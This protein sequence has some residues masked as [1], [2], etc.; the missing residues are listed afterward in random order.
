MRIALVAG[1]TSGDALG[2]ELIES[3]RALSPNSEFFGIGGPGMAA[4]GCKSWFQSEELSVM[5]L[6]EVLRHLPRLFKVRSDLIRKLL[7]AKPD[8]FVGIDS[9]DFNLPVED[10]LREKGIPTVQYVSPQVWA[11]RR[12]RVARIRKATDLVLCVLPFEVDFYKQHDVKAVFV[13]HPLADQIPLTVSQKDARSGLGFLGTAPL[14]AVLPGSRRSEVSRL[15]RPFFETLGWLTEHR[16]G[17]VFAVAFSSQTMRDL[18]MERTAGIDV[19]PEPKFFVGK[20][21]EVIAAS[22]VVL[23]A[24]GTASLEATLLKRP[25]V[26]AYR[27]SPLTHWMLNSMGVRRL[28]NF[29]LPNLLAAKSLMP[30]YLQ[31][32]VRAQIL[33]P[34]LLNFL[35]DSRLNPYW[36]DAF[37]AIHD[38][39]RCGASEQ[40]A[41]AVISLFERRRH[42]LRGQFIGSKGK[43][44]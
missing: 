12:S 41:Q 29:S 31:A 34:A 11:W 19:N 15:S 16:S 32:Q 40:A 42:D 36:Y 10:V 3:I 25:M 43:S 28:Q 9:P 14:V 35:D 18:F 24:S 30:E 39:L 22:D 33:G 5:G 21:R 4:V 37:A 38:Q 27:M 44:R 8:V 1:E 20:A 17:L 2:A 23:T 7:E 26:V 13:G 6:T